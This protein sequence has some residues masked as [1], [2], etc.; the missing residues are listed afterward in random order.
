MRT[1]RCVTGLR[2]IERIVLTGTAPLTIATGLGTQTIIGN[3]AGNRLSGGAGPD[4]IHGGG[5]PDLIVLGSDAFDT[6]SGGAG[7]D[8][9]RPTGTPAVVRGTGLPAGAVAHRILDFD[10]AEED[11]IVLT[12]GVYGTSVRQLE[13][14]FRVVSSTAPQA[15]VRGAALLWNTSTH[16]LSFDRDGTG[17]ISPKVIAILPTVYGIS[18]SMFIIS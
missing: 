10:L 8:R 9:F 11:R 6:V 14:D 13:R 18:P 2:D 16:L 3:S 12:S 4:R 17:P 1:S 15:E 5:G 7:A